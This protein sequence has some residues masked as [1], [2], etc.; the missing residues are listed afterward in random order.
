MIHS[1]QFRIILA[2]SL[3]ILVTIGS[4]FFFFGQTAKKEIDRFEER[5]ERQLTIKIS[6]ELSRY[7]RL[8]GSWE[9][10]QP[11]I[12][13]WGSLSERRI[14]LVDTE[15]TTVA[16]TQGD[17]LGKPYES[18]SPGTTLRHPL[19]QNTLG[20]LY[21]GEVKSNSLYMLYAK[22]GRFFIWGACVAIGVALLLTFFLSK[23]ISAP[24]LALATTARK[25]GQGD[26]SQR[27]DV[28]D[29]SEVG[30]L[31]QAFNSMASDLEKAEQLR[32]N[33][34]ADIAHEPVAL[35]R[36]H[37]QCPILL[38]QKAVLLEMLL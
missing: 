25:L 14:I 24:I 36:Y 4:I 26:L 15:G 7:Y 13:R 29:K 12:E 3:V 22:V 30:E 5:I 20:T 35:T 8:Q 38:T 34:V 33:M 1:L 28:Q 2:F 17:L 10:I 9:G 37:N 16:D 23:R 11:F 21:I 32:K 31:A 19:E 27:V 6:I 18:D